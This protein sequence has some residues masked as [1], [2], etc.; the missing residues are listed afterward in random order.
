MVNHQVTYCG[1][2]GLSCSVVGA[3]HGGRG[4]HTHLSDA[5]PP[6]T[7]CSST[8]PVVSQG[9]KTSNIDFGG[10]MKPDQ[11]NSCDAQTLYERG[12][13]RLGR[14]WQGW[15]VSQVAGWL[16][17]AGLLLHALLA[18]L[19]A[20]LLALPTDLA[21]LV[22]LLRRRVCGD[23]GDCH[24]NT[25]FDSALHL[26][27]SCM[28]GLG[29]VL[30]VIATVF[31]ALSFLLRKNNKEKNLTAVTRLLTIICCIKEGFQILIQ[32][33]NIIL[34]LIVIS[35]IGFTVNSLSVILSV[36]TVSFDAMML[37]GI[38]TKKSSF[39]NAFLVFHYVLFFIVLGVYLIGSVVSAAMF[40][41][42]WIVLL[43][44]LFAMVFIFFFV[45][46]I[47]FY[48]VLHTITLANEKKHPK[49]TYKNNIAFVNDA[50]RQC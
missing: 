9:L 2:S 3:R 4:P 25:L 18:L 32:S 35:R 45:Y 37:H 13:L 22:A 8:G 49:S 27:T 47:G 24:D 5:D 34:Q 50:Y 40:Q 23:S 19:A 26:V 12:Q 31:L 6:I 36:V 33:A 17:G 20:A 15:R 28:Y 42:F 16:A 43:G 1:L 7:S 14:A 30:L 39:M 10:M 21:W 41:Q 46:N 38:R 29:A 11:D 48:A 44:I